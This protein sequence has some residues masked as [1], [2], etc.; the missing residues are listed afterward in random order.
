MAAAPAHWAGCGAQTKVYCCSL[1]IVSMIGRAVDETQP[2]AG[3]G[4]AL[5]EAVDHER[6]LVEP[7]GDTNGPS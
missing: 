5:A 1:I 4:V 7:A 2:P 6:L 3:H